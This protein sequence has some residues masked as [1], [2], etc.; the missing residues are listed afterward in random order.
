MTKI[1]R[2]LATC[3]KQHSRSGRAG[4]PHRRAGWQGLD[5]KQVGLLLMLRATCWPF[6]VPRARENAWHPATP[7][8]ASFLLGAIITEMG[9]AKKGN[10][11]F[12]PYQV[13]SSQ[14]IQK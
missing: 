14:L 7:R 10:I 12:P 11:Y 1:Q 5:L 3:P 8:V 2:G 9:N 4:I 13:T 6:H